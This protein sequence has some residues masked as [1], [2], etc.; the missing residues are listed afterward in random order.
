MD[1]TPP[2]AGGYGLGP[3]ARKA[4]H[5]AGLALFLVSLTYVGVFAARNW[6][7]I[8]QTPP[9]DYDRLALAGVLYALA[10]PFSAAAWV[11]G[12]RGLRQAIP[13]IAGI[14]IALATQVGKYLP[15]NVAHYFARAALAAASGVKVASSGI[16]TLVE[17]LAALLAAS[18]VASVAM[19]F[20]PAPIAALH[21]ALAR[22]AALPI[23]VAALAAIGAGF[24]LYRF[25]VP[26]VAVLAATACLMVNFAFA[27][28]SFLAVVSALSGSFLSPA[29]MIGI[30]SIAWAAGYL[31]PGA[32]AGIGIREAILVAWLG[33]I[34]GAGPAIACSLLHRV[35]TALV[36]AMVA[37]LSYGWLRLAKARS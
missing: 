1:G 26:A 9:L 18:L 17:I 3:R 2:P 13:F 6:Q 34:I 37:L 16:A 21:M 27:G 28:L 8:E 25:K 36:D 10:H 12:L 15:G 31:V 19:L 7:S 24:V 30:F 22:S 32:P 23:A 33:P 14:R 11:L 29:A 4:L 20:D 5:F 35:I